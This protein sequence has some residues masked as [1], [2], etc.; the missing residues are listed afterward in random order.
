[1]RKHGDWW[2]TNKERTDDG[3]SL[4]YQL[5]VSETD[6]YWWRS[7]I[8]YYKYIISYFDLPCR[9]FV[10]V[11]SSYGFIAR[12]VSKIFKRVH[13]FEPNPM[14]YRCLTVNMT[15]VKNATLYKKGLSNRQHSII[16]YSNE[17]VSTHSSFVNNPLE[18]ATE[19]LAYCITLDSLKLSSVDFL[20]IDAENW[21]LRVIKGALETIQRCRP[22]IFVECN[23][24]F[25]D[26]FKTLYD[27]GYIL[28]G[29]MKVN[30]YMFIHEDKVKRVKDVQR[31]SMGRKI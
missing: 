29:V 9:S 25:F 18:K 12:P 10:D 26:T 17:K 7:E 2:I 4:Y 13:C 27:M 3:T 21:E 22:A 20:K 6:P 5:L 28:V 15:E 31:F 30:N 11:G 23:I 24:T 16:L 8:E 19:V 14:V 1:L